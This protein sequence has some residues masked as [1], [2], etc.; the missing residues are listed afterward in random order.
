MTDETTSRAEASAYD[1]APGLGR[2]G[3]M[4]HPVSSWSCCGALS[5]AMPLGLVGCPVGPGSPE[6][7]N[8]SAGED[9]SRVLVG[10]SAC[11]GAPV[12]VGGPGG[13][14][15]GMIREAGDRPPETMI[16]GPSEDDAAA[17]AGSMGNWAD[18]GLGGELLFGLE[19][20][21]HVAE[22]GKD[23]GGAEAAGARE[24]HDDLAVGQFSDLVLDASGEG[25]NLV[26]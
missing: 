2:G 10:A 23:L 8:P 17:L 13:A 12:D 20:L 22:L 26:A 16:A 21:T 1:A 19:A 9:S 11:S 7:A 15:A 24:G 18:A 14:V 5:G 4:R 25:G 6:N 3:R